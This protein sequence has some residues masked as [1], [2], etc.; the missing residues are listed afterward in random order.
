MLAEI[1]MGLSSL[2]AASDILKGLNAANTQAA[3][4]DVK[5]VLQPHII[6]AQQALAAANEA[7]ATIRKVTCTLTQ[8][9]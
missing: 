1:S 9:L 8:M 4:N 5:L 2:K 3:I 6:D 7:Q